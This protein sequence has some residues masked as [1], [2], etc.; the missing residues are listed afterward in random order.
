M[1][2]WINASLG[3]KDTPCPLLWTLKPGL[4]LTGPYQLCFLLQRSPLEG[5]HPSPISFQEWPHPA[6]GPP[7]PGEWG[8]RGWGD[9]PGG[10][11]KLHSSQSVCCPC[12]FFLQKNG[13]SFSHSTHFNSFLEDT[14][15]NRGKSLWHWIWQCFVEYD[16]E[17]TCTKSRNSQVELYQT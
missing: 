4:S 14:I 3:L 1:S 17:S 5:F 6:S 16:T 10:Y 9:V 8:L 13:T 2:A 15:K 11:G 7:T 12:L